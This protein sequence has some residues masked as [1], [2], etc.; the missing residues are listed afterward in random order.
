MSLMH[1]NS[2]ANL[3]I[4]HEATAAVLDEDARV[5]AVATATDE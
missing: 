4:A 1:I 5:A 3:D 2:V